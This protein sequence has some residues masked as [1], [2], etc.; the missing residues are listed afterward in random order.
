MMNMMMHRRSIF[1]LPLLIAAGLI[2]QASSAW[3]QAP[4]V[5]LLSTTTLLVAVVS[6]EDSSGDAASTC[7]KLFTGSTAAEVTEACA[8]NCCSGG[9]DA[10]VCGQ[11]RPL[12][13]SVRVVAWERMHASLKQKM[14]G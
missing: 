11:H 2:Q 1:I 10:C 3:L 13:E 12:F 14:Q 8:G 9:V 5:G 7:T 6:A 4:T